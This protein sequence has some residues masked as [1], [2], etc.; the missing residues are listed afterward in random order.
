MVNTNKSALDH[1]NLNAQGVY[2]HAANTNR[3]IIRRKGAYHEESNSKEGHVSLV[4]EL[5]REE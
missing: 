4:M 2:L 1:H 3:K 5:G